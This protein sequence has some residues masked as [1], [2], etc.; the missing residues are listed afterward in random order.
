M[1]FTVR[2]DF[3]WLFSK[4]LS[5]SNVCLHL[6]VNL[7]STHPTKCHCSQYHTAVK[8]NTFRQLLDIL[9]KEVSIYWAA[10]SE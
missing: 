4:W 1:C 10:L 5:Y 9:F 3:C 7:K 6:Q 8:S 2:L